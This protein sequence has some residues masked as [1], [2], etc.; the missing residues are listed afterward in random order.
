M[1]GNYITGAKNCKAMVKHAIEKIVLWSE[2]SFSWIN[3]FVHWIC[4]KLTNEIMQIFNNNQNF[5]SESYSFPKLNENLS[6]TTMNKL[7]WMIWHSVTIKMDIIDILEKKSIVSIN[8][9][10]SLCTKSKY[11]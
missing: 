4:V 11:M 9:S 10:F 6:A 1:I 5:I 3:F 7:R 2:I 8:Q